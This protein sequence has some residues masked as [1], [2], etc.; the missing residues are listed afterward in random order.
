[1]A[2]LLLPAFKGDPLLWNLLGDRLCGLRRFSGGASYRLRFK[3]D[4]CSSC[5]RCPGT[6]N[7]VIEETIQASRPGL[8]GASPKRVAQKMF[9]ECL[10]VF[11]NSVLPHY[12]NQF[13]SP[14]S[15]LSVFSE[16]RNLAMNKSINIYI[17][18]CAVSP[19]VFLQQRPINP[20][21]GEFVK[22]HPAVLITSLHRP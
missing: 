9:F 18:I 2:V 22:A 13:S 10:N 11:S 8:W 14:G 4:V 5:E 19:P 21:W 6:P 3:E 1:M 15:P 20:G 12:E 7:C 16:T 17:N